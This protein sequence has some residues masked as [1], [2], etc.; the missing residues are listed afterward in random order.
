MLDQSS[1]QTEILNILED[2]GACSVTDLAA[3]FEVSDETV[4]RDIRQLEAHGYVLK[5][6]GGVR[7]P[8]NVF[9][10]AY[11]QRQSEHS[12]AKK[13]IG[14]CASGLVSDGMSLFLDG[15]TTASRVARSLTGQ[16]NLSIVTNGI[17]VAR[18]LI[19]R[20][21]NRVFLAGGQISDTYMCTFGPTAIEFV[22][23]FRV[24]IAFIGADSVDPN[25]GYCD[26]H[27]PEVE[28][29]RTMLT[30]A[31]KVVVVVDSSKF[32]RCGLVRIADFHEVDTLITNEPPP[33]DIVRLMGET[34]IILAQ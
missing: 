5:T 17:E 33:D 16:R 27:L 4:R 21:N 29:V 14:D 11:R 18:D 25:V 15:S 22:S 3:R 30:H 19:G 9:V 20:N 1:R 32:K 31:R 24:D 34:E 23:Q 7:L 2:E 26:A 8:D 13:R 6:H 10:A 12:D 28:L